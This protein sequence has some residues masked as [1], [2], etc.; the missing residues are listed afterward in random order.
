M[1]DMPENSISEL[2][3]RLARSRPVPHPAFRGRLRRHLFSDQ[4]VVSR[5]A[6]LRRL[7]AGYATSGALL[8]LVAAVGLA[9]IGPLSA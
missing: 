8:L 9:G 1:S 7:I 4:G 5:P 6:G 2:E 3:Q